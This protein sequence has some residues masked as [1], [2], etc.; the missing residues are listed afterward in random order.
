MNDMRARY[1]NERVMTATPGQRVVMLYD[2]LALDLTRAADIYATDPTDFYSAGQA[3][4]HAMA[5]VA[6]LAGSLRPTPNSPSDNL[7]SIYGYLL[8]ELSAVRGGAS[9]RLAGAA[10]IVG[11]LRKAWTEAVASTAPA[12]GAATAWVG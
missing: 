4:D 7:A 2:R 8:K 12:S 5:I 10:K 3:I 9:A 11:T 1:L 6:E